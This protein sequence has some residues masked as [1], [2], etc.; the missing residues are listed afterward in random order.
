MI[1]RNPGAVRFPPSRLA[2]CCAI[3]LLVLPT[4]DAAAQTGSS[5]YLLRP[6]SATFRAIVRDDGDPDFVQDSRFRNWFP[7]LLVVEKPEEDSGALPIQIA[8]PEP[9]VIA[10][11]SASVP[12]T[13]SIPP[14]PTAT[15]SLPPL[16]T[17]IPTVSIP[18]RPTPPPVPTP[19]FPVPPPNPAPTLAPPPL[20]PILQPLAWPDFGEMQRLTPRIEVW[21][22]N[23]TRPQIPAEHGRVADHV[24]VTGVD[25][26]TLR[27]LFNPSA[28]GERVLV[29]ASSGFALDPPAQ[30]LVVSSQGECFVTGQLAEGASR[31]QIM[32]RC[33]MIA[34][35]VPVVRASL[36][37]VERAEAVTGGSP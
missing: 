22:S 36:A 1:W 31:G 25:L 21:R 15:P 11:P 29:M 20:R 4:R 18:P 28:A 12:P 26:V 13:P 9:A 30:V 34:V 32:V 10:A 14:L 24:F 33:K 17:A 16:P 6:S 37:V 3:S 5:W 7:E 2:L 8:S 19:P 35:R 23:A 27:L